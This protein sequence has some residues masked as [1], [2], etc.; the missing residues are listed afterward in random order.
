M[1]SIQAYVS[2]SL[3]GLDFMGKYGF[4]PYTDAKKP[5]IL[6]GFY[7]GR[8]YE[9]L[10]SHKGKIYISWQGMDSTTIPEFMIKELCKAEHF[11]LSRWVYEALDRRGIKSELIT[12]TAT[13]DEYNAEPMGESVYFY[14]NVSS[15]ENNLYYGGDL[16][17]EV[18]KKTGY[19][20]ITGWYGKFLR[21]EM[22]DIYRQ[23]FLN[24]RLT[25]MDGFPNTNMEMGLMGRRSVFNGG[26]ACSLTYK[27]VDDICFLIDR[28]YK[29]R[30]MK[31][32]EMT[33]QTMLNFKNENEKRFKEV[34]GMPSML[35]H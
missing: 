11:A 34:I 20:I 5:V 35:I 13:K 3:E 26:G 10:L 9:I 7:R 8:E 19:N 22:R 1:D 15:E 32:A 16:I 18:K 24:L 27:T 33:R 2:E 30:S 31:K 29:E 14:T 17:E 21:N 12:I 25:K 28:E 23:C 6:F 4:E